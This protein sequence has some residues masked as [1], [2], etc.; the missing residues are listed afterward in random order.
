MLKPIALSI[1]QLIQN[2]Q[3]NNYKRISWN[4]TGSRKPLIGVK[5]KA[6][7]QA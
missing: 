3:W 7:S 6:C 4:E 1:T 2:I 5:Q